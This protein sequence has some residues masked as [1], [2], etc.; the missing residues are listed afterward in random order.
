MNLLGLSLLEVLA[1]ILW[2]NVFLELSLA[3]NGD[4]CLM[5]STLSLMVPLMTKG[6]A[7]IYL[8]IECFA[9]CIR[10]AHTVPRV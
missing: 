1:I 6:F 3:L 10:Y 5:P 7:S 2:L 4:S 9:G 8:Q